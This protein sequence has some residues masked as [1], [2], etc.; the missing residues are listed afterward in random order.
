[1]KI[2]KSYTF[3][4]AHFLPQ[5]P[6]GHPCRRIHG[7]SWKMELHFDGELV[8]PY[9]WVIDFHEIDSVVDP[10]YKI[11]DHNFLNEVEGLENPTSEVISIWV[12]N[13]IKEQLPALCKVVIYETPEA[14][15]EYVGE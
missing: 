9:E 15:T 10:I 5:M 13:K 8:L 6:E 4:A 14:G 2:F 11:L 1:M 3:E 7:H 12:W